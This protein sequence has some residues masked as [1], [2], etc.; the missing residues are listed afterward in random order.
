MA[1]L[2]KESIIIET[3]YTRPDIWEQEERQLQDVARGF[4]AKHEG[5]LVGEV[6]RWQRADGYAQY[7]VIKQAPLTLAHIEIGDAWYVEGPLIRGLRL[8]DARAM[9]QRERAMQDM[10]SKAK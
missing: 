3:D 4:R 10:F 5:E 7:M 8:E 6:L 1:K 2:A 9:V